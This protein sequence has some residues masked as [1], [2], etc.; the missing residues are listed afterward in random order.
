LTVSADLSSSTP[1]YMYPTASAAIFLV[2]GVICRP[3]CTG[4]DFSKVGCDLLADSSVLADSY[5]RQKCC[6]RV[7]SCGEMYWVNDV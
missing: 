5:G 6:S 3:A 4:F 7:E 1:P 2:G